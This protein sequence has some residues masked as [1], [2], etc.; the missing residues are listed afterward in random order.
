MRTVL[1]L[2]H[3]SVVYMYKLTISG[4]MEKADTH[5]LNSDDKNLKRFTLIKQIL[6]RIAN[7]SNDTCKDTNL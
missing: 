1:L 2:L 4:R 5:L 7:E 6:A 3:K